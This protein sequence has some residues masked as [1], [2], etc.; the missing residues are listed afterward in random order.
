MSAP[1]SSLT[2]LVAAIRASDLPATLTEAERREISRAF[3]D[4]GWCCMPLDAM[5]NGEHG[6]SMAMLDRYLATRQ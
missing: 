3:R 5:H 1:R 2:P 4:I 6:R